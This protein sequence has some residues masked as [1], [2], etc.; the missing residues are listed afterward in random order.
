M[1]IKQHNPYIGQWIPSDYRQD[2]YQNDERLLPFLT[3]ALITAPLWG[4][5][6]YPS[7]IP[8]SYPYPYFYQPY[9]YPYYGGYYP[10]YPMRHRRYYY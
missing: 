2:S 3:G 10:R 5:G 6:R 9:G 4:I 7:Y 8:Y 1:N